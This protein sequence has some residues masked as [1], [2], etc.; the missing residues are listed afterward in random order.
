MLS[1]GLEFAAA[2]GKEANMCRLPMLPALCVLL[3]VGVP[4]AYADSLTLDFEYEFSEADTPGGTWPFLT[5]TFTDVGPD[6]VQ[7]T[8][9]AGN[10]IDSEFVHAWYFNFD[11]AGV[12]GSLTATYQ[13]GIEA[14][15]VSFSTN[16][17]KADGDGY[18]DIGFDFLHD[19]KL[20]AGT[21]SVYLLQQTDLTAGLFMFPS[22]DGNDPLKNDFLSAAH[23]GGIGAGGE[24]SGW[25]AGRERHDVVVPEPATVVL[26]GAGLVALHLR[27]RRRTQR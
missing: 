27:R 11:P 24:G 15:A 10:L 9:D 5:A 12:L 8:M 14:G 22:V 21:T 3:M 1:R 6:Q 23:V 25:L 26:V 4:P 2:A 16:A 13:S 18:F 19:R 17:F 7:L 20:G